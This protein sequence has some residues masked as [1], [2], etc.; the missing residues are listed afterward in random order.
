MQ[1]TIF[2]YK[3]MQLKPVMCADWFYVWRGHAELQC[4]K[5]YSC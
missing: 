1:L 4:Q 3:S 5:M 2:A